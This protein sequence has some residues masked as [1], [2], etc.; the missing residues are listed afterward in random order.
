[1]LTGHFINLS[2]KCIIYNL[3]SSMGGEFWNKIHNSTHGFS[4][5]MQFFHRD[6]TLKVSSVKLILN[7]A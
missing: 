3:M 6:L 5:E 2:L 1:M 4:S 7:N